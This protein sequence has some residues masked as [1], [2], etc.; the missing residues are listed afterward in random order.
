MLQVHLIQISVYFLILIVLL[1]SVYLLLSIAYFNIVH[2]VRMKVV[3][4]QVN[5]QNSSRW[6]VEFLLLDTSP[7]FWLVPINDISLFEALEE[8]ATDGLESVMFSHM[9]IYNENVRDLLAPST[10]PKGQPSTEY[11][12]VRE[13]PTKGIFVSNLT[14][15][16]VT[17]FEDLMSLIAIGDKNRTVG[18]TNANAHSSRY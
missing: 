17:N 10:S 18:A 12:R 8:K 3:I 2:T 5:E 7:N 13:H 14:T 6:N 1:F 16:R 11:L 4:N 15:I 9:E